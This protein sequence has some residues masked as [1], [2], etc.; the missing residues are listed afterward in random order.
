MMYRFS[1]KTKKWSLLYFDNINEK[2][3]P[4]CTLG[5]LNGVL[6][7]LGGRSMKVKKHF[8]FSDDKNSLKIHILI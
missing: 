8:Y 5:I 4:F 1:F 3:S 2:G 6:Y 7:R